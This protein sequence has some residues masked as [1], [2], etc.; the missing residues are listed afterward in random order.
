MDFGYN[1]GYEY[2]YDYPV[3]MNSTGSLFTALMY[4]YLI[5][6]TVIVIFALASYIFHSVGMYTI[7]KRMGREYAWLAFIP[8]ARDY[9]HGEL[10]GAIPLKSRKIKNPGIWNLVLPIIYNAIAGILIVIVVIAGIGA[11]VASEMNRGVTGISAF[12]SALIGVYVLIL[13]LAV[14]YT[15]IH[16]VLRVLID[17]QIYERFTSRNM[18]VVH[19]VLSAIL[20][21]Y[22]SICFFVMRNRDFNPGMEPHIAPPVPPV[23]PM[24]PVPPVSHVESGN[25]EMTSEKPQDKAADRKEDTL[26]PPIGE[27]T[28]HKP[29]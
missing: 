25:M 12:I 2:N 27:Q 26:Q 6:L 9:F 7:G 29:E 8:F 16:S 10:A 24:P 13:I 19:S 4:I 15:A 17:I 18:A 1:Y 23:P 21:L 20:P 11:G 5:I 22:E 3:H 14:A 28:D